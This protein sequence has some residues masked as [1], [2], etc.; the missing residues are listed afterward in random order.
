MKN[1]RGTAGSQNWTMDVFG[2]YIIFIFIV[3]LAAVFF[4]YSI[5]GKASAKTAISEDVEILNLMQRFLESP[6]CFVMSSE[7]IVSSGIIDAAKFNQDRLNSCY[8]VGNANYIAFKLGLKST[9][10]LAY[11]KEIRGMN[12]NDN[13]PPEKKVSKQV[14]IFLEGK[15]VNGEISIEIQNIR[16]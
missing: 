4:A 12:W 5:S 2:F 1:K 7:S 15:T 11:E 13:R 9:S 14:I 3:S 16:K 10:Q 6:E 8:K